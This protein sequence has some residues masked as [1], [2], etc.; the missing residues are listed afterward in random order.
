MSDKQTTS[1]ERWNRAV[2]VAFEVTP[3]DLADEVLAKSDAEVVAELRAGGVDVEAFDAE[4]DALFARL[5][6]AQEAEAGLG[7]R[8]PEAW[9]SEGPPPVARIGLRRR[10]RALLAVAAVAAA[11]AAGAAAYLGAQHEEE[12]KEKPAPVPSA[13][14]APSAVKEAPSAVPSVKEGE[15][16]SA[17][18]NG[19]TGDKAPR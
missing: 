15:S 1:V 7:E 13:S 16:K 2:R 19:G 11:S 6:A 17:P 9:T 14:A 18:R 10:N 4:G 5:L 3:D 8:V 12:K